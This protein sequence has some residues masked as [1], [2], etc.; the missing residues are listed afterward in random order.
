MTSIKRKC[1]SFEAKLKLIGVVEKGDKTKA[2]ICSENG[3]AQSS[4]STILKESQKIRTVLEQGTH[5]HKKQRTLI[6]ADVDKG[7][8]LQF[9]QA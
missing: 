8:V 4:L 1:I 9:K 7:L 6:Y 5:Q 3:I 2:E